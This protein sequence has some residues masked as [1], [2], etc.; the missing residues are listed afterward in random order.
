MELVEQYQRGLVAFVKDDKSRIPEVVSAI[1]PTDEEVAEYRHEAKPTLRKQ[2]AGPTMEILFRENMSWL[3]WLMFEGEPVSALRKLSEL[4]VGQRGVCGAVWGHKDIAYRCRTCEHDPTCA[5][6]VPCFQNGNHKDHDYSV[7][8]TSGGCCDCGD[9]M[10]WKREGFCSKHKGAEQIQPLPEEFANSVGPVLDALFV[11]W[12]NKLLIVETTCQENPRASDRTTER[13]KFATEL[14]FVV[15]E[16]LLDFCKQSESL[17]SFISKRLFSS[18]GLL[19]MLVR[20][21]RFVNGGVVKKLHELLL[22]LLGEPVFKYEFAKVFLGYY[23]IVVSEVIKECNDSALKKYPLLSTFSV[24]IFTVPTLTPRLV[25]EM[26][27]LSMLLGC[28]G[29]IFSSCA[30]EDGRLQVMHYLLD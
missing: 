15:V 26:N 30:G 23:P 22:K 2:L 25:K 28:L 1:L 17:L 29:D 19:E 27:L 3:Q 5:I 13:K 21:E 18:F 8:Y 20:A 10:A 9:V 7:M 14:T 6:C 4:S 16:M 24:Q 12:K 11:C